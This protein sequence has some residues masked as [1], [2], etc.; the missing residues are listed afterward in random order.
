[1]A[2][3]E[4]GPPCHPFHVGS[5]SARDSVLGLVLDSW[6]HRQNPLRRERGRSREYVLNRCEL[7]PGLAA[8]RMQGRLTGYSELMS[9]CE[10]ARDVAN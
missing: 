1:M 8:R 3:V 5:N 10:L 6:F 9:Q 4:T 7:V 2:A